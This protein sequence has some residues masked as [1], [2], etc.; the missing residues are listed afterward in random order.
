MLKSDKQRVVDVYSDKDVIGLY[1]N[2][3]FWKVEKAV[4]DRFIPKNGCW[5]IL[6]AGCGAGRT[7]IELS[8]MGNIVYGI[9]VSYDILKSAKINEV[10]LSKIHFINA[11]L[12]NLPIRESALDCIVSFYSVLGIIIDKNERK[13]II[14]ESHRIVK[15]NGLLIFHVHNLLYPGFFG[16]RWIIFMIYVLCNLLSKRKLEF[17]TRKVNETGQKLFC[18]YFT[19]SE[20]RKLIKPQFKLIAVISSKGSWKKNELSSR[21]LFCED[22]FVVCSKRYLSHSI[23]K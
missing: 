3:G 22:Y 13:A 7:S 20:I 17:G 5:K 23:M 19:L 11:D 4:V 8:K 9:D 2:I 18:H 10:N 1:K 14:E 6:D 16:K 12:S 15:K 21:K